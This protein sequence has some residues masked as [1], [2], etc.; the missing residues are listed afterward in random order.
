MSPIRREITL[1]QNADEVWEL[2]STADGLERWLADEVE[3]EP[4]AGGTVRTRTGERDVRTGTVEHVDPG[5][6][7]TFVWRGAADAPTRVTI[8]ISTTGVGTR[9]AVSETS[10]TGRLSASTAELRTMA[11]RLRLQ[12]LA[13]CLVVA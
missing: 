10:L 6:S 1:E 11:W 13:G 9:L 2:I 5:R 3:L 8:A 4:I 12:V 7:L